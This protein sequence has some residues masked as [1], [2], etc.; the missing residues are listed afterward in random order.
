[1]SRTIRRRDTPRAGREQSDRRAGA[2][3]RRG[4][5]GGIA[6]VAIA[7]SLSLGT[8]CSGGEEDDGRGPVL[9]HLADAGTAAFA[10]FAAEAE[11]L[12]GA[13]EALCAAPSAAALEEAQTRWRAT[14]RAW[15]AAA[16]F[17]FGPAM[18]HVSALDYWPVRIDTI[19]AQIAAAPPT[20]DVAYIDGLGTSAKGMPAL[21]LLLFGA[22]SDPAGALAA[23][24]EPMS[25]GAR[26]AYAAALAGD[27]HGRAA[28]I[29][30]AWSG[31]FADALA[32]AGEGS[33]LFPTRKAGIDAAVN[34]A[35]EVL[36]A[37][38][39]T[40]L[41]GPLGNLTGAPVDPEALESRFAR[42]TRDDLAA[43]LASVWVAYHGDDPAG[44]LEGIG[45]LVAA[46]D[47]DLDAR[48]HDQEG[49]AAEAIAALAEPAGEALVADRGPFQ[50][51]RDE[52]DTLR[53]M[54][55]LDVAS[56]LGVTL[57]L[58]DNDGD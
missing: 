29:A 37:I 35:I 4:L 39:H 46:I 52:V 17:L 47:P 57:S 9:R 21:E 33:E 36:Y 10:D 1:M 54:L 8:S 41:D 27:V 12:A 30:D 6:G 14:R 40:K 3:G 44:P 5:V 20:I 50:A 42:A 7:F 22:E 51:A 28:T 13:T 53:R 19:E 11:A 15:S 43:N 32:G 34:Q 26:C 48:I 31:G 18:D 23:I 24:T 16:A 45:A 56:A 2:F 55:K 58:S 49:Y 38:V 25:G